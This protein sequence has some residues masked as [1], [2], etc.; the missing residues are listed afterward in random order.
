LTGVTL[1]AAGGADGL[2]EKSVDAVDV[3]VESDHANDQRYAGRSDIPHDC[4]IVAI[5]PIPRVTEVTWDADYWLIGN[6]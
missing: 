4:Q 6:S 5:E 2:P 3:L 1:V